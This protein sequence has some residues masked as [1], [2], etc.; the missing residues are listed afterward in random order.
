MRPAVLDEQAWWSVGRAHAA[1]L[2]RVGGAWPVLLGC[3][4]VA[5]LASLA[6]H[7]VLP[8]DDAGTAHLAD[9]LPVVLALAAG[10]GVHAGWWCESGAFEGAL[11]L[12]PDRRRLL[13]GQVL[14]TALVVAGVATLGT[15][16]LT[17]LTTGLGS[18]GNSPGVPYAPVAALFAAAM[19]A[20]AV[21][22]GILCRRPVLAGLALGGLW[23]VLPV[24]LGSA[25]TWLDGGARAFVDS[26]V[27]A[28]PT[29][30]AV[31]G[32]SGDG[33]SA[34]LGG[35]LGQVTWAVALV[36]LTW[37]ELRRRDH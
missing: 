9:A 5:A 31:S 27:D 29:R 16:V 1:V 3:L 18:A 24:L 2:V 19:T 21:T 12:V 11:A 15:A 13:V 32:L 34:T 7:A 20:Q 6:A 37:A 14:G 25:R 8:L 30:L 28:G 17:V 36:A 33:L 35:L 22:L 26:L 10:A 23:I 4:A